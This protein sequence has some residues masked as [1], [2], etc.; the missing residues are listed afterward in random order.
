MGHLITCIVGWLDVWYVHVD[1]G[2]Y[3]YIWLY[4]C[5]YVYINV[6]MYVYMYPCMNTRS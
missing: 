5:I 2:G 4:V 3:T 6:Q 1:M